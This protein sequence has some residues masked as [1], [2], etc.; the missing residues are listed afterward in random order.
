MGLLPA[1]P[2]GAEGPQFGDSQTL[3][4]PAWLSAR[5]RTQC[6]S[7]LRAQGVWVTDLSPPGCC[8]EKDHPACSALGAGHVVGA[9]YSERAAPERPEGDPCPLYSLLF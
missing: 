8:R 6:L 3:A 2:K 4:S 7:Q 5:M 9:G 1:Q